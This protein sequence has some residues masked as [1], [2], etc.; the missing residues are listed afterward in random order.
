VCGVRPGLGIPAGLAL[1]GLA[2]CDRLW[3][4]LGYFGAD[5]RM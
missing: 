1:H 4:G 2:L 5:S 3:A